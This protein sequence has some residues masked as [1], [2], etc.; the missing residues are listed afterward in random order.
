MGTGGQETDW[1][2]R[3]LAIKGRVTSCPAVTPETRGSVCRRRGKGESRPLTRCKGTRDPPVPSLSFTATVCS[4]DLQGYRAESG[5]PNRSQQG[6][7]DPCFPSSSQPPGPGTS[8]Y[9]SPI[10]A[11]GKSFF[12]YC[13]KIIKAKQ[14]TCNKFHTQ[15]RSF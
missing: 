5:K 2:V 4:Q 6:R 1:A 14:K 7:R 8:Q 12:L 9:P 10:I 15:R 13:F 3:Q 11:Q